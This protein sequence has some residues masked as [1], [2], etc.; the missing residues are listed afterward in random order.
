MTAWE[1]TLVIILASTLAV[2]LV[3]SIIA[4]IKIIQILNQV[5]RI[6]TKAEQ[7]TEKAEAIG[8]FFKRANTANAVIGTITGIIHG[9][10]SKS[11]KGRKK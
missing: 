6:T 11:K 4:V 8:D 2:F 1:Q 7:L 3:L 5:K 9:V 10:K